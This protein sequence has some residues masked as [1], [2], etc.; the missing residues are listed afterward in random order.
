[1][2][3]SAEKIQLLLLFLRENN[4]IIWFVWV[5]R[6]CWH[7]SIKIRYQSNRGETTKVLPKQEMHT[8]FYMST[9]IRQQRDLVEYEISW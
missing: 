7:C 3:N 1:M 4:G 9:R 8:D 2:E 5:H 6:A